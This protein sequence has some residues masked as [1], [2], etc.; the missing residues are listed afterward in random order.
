MNRADITNKI[1]EATNLTQAEAEEALTAFLNVVK[2]SLKNGEKVT[3]IGFGSFSVVDRKA[4]TGRNPRTG[5]PIEIPA[6]RAVKF[7]PA[8]KLKE[9]VSGQQI[10]SS[11]NS[12]EVDE[13]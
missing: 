2:D 6:A 12:T 11:S 4:R 1:V 3:L 7:K 5:E 13:G 9:V 8:E 10:Q